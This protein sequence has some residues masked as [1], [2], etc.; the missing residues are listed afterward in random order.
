MTGHDTK[1]TSLNDV[2]KTIIG[3]VDLDNDHITKVSVG[4][5]YNGGLEVTFVVDTSI[6]KGGCDGKE[7]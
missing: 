4:S 1:R 7:N 2:L 5:S 6:D 3:C